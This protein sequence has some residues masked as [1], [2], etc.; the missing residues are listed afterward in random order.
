MRSDIEELGLRVTRQR[1]R[2]AVHEHSPEAVAFRLRKLIP[3]VVYCS[4][5]PHHRW[6]VDAHMKLIVW[7][8]VI[9]GAIHGFSRLVV[10]LEAS[11]SNCN[12]NNLDAFRRAGAV[13]GCPAHIRM[14]KGS[15]NRYVAKYM[16][17]KSGIK[18]HEPTVYAG[19]SVHNQR[20]ERL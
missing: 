8:F 16:F 10:Y 13:N 15:E 5:G 17:E 9:N 19:V 14:D 11:D 3:R 12:I 4:A 18:E 7:G 20:I 6:H 1:L 2:D